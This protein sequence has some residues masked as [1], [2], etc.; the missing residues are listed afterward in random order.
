MSWKERRA[1]EDEMVGWH[2]R[3]SG[4]EL[5]QAPGVGDRQGSLACCNA[6]GYKESDMTERLN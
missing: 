6:W 5:E 3:L 2:H 1:S 4:H